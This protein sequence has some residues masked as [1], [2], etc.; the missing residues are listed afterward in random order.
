MSVLSRAPRKSRFFFTDKHLTINCLAIEQQQVND[1]VLLPGMI[2]RL[3][4]D[5]F[6]ISR[7]VSHCYTATSAPL[8]GDIYKIAAC[9]GPCVPRYFQPP[10]NASEGF[11]SS[12]TWSRKIPPSQVKV[13]TTWHLLSSQSLSWANTGSSQLCQHYLGLKPARELGWSWELPSQWWQAVSASPNTIPRKVHSL[14]EPIQLK[15]SPI[16][17]Q[18]QFSQF[19]HADS[20]DNQ[21][22]VTCFSYL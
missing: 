15:H 8:Q 10:Q 11:T 12:V 2:P 5:W 14:L 1:S 7:Q 17:A 19:R 3:L 4:H 13:Y 21:F 16:I 9:P 22:S 6:L 18:W 20:W